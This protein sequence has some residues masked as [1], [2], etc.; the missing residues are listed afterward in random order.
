MGITG[1]NEQSSKRSV[2]ENL[3]ICHVS[4]NQYIK[5][6]KASEL[7]DSPPKCGYNIHT[8]IFNVDQEI[9][10]SNYLQNCADIYFGLSINDA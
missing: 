10:I 7:G 8:R 2:T 6:F 4:L 5:K 1:I 9:I 3:D